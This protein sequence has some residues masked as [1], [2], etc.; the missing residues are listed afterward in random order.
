MFINIKKLIIYLT[1]SI[2]AKESYIFSI[3]VRLRKLSSKESKVSIIYELLF[4]VN[5]LFKAFVLLFYLDFIME[6]IFVGPNV[7]LLIVSVSINR[8]F[9]NDTFNFK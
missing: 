7:D 2:I 8:G 6:I 4:Y 1:N 9:K 3:K 5:I